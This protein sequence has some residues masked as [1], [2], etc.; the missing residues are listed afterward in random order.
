MHQLIFFL[1]ELRQF[2]LVD[3][4]NWKLRLLLDAPTNVVDRQSTKKKKGSGKR[5]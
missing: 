3:Y 5:C 4:G 1:K 2:S